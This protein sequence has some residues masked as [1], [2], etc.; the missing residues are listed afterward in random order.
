MVL[1]EVLG[2]NSLGLPKGTIQA[3][4]DCLNHLT[5]QTLYTYEVLQL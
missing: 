2:K 4:D 3:S 1:R 5:I